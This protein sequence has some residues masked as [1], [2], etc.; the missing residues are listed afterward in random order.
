MTPPRSVKLNL[1]L[2]ILISL[3]FKLH[4]DWFCSFGGDCI[5]WGLERLRYAPPYYSLRKS[6]IFPSSIYNVKQYIVF[7][8]LYVWGS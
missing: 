6:V 5:Q 2:Q 4:E 1:C 8:Y 7:L 3:Y